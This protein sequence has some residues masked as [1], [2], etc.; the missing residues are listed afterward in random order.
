M[1][2][3]RSIRDSTFNTESSFTN[4]PARALAKSNGAVMLCMEPVW[5]QQQR[6]SNSYY[7]PRLCPARLSILLYSIHIHLCIHISIYSISKAHNDDDDDD[8][9]GTYISKHIR[10][11]ICVCVVHVL[12]HLV[13]EY[14]VR[15]DCA[16]PERIICVSTT[17]R[18]TNTTHYAFVTALYIQ[19]R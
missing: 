12:Y 17:T 4:A 11:R 16:K 7:S 2:I 9:I 1:H 6:Q 18:Y 5:S 10:T 14:F 15:S 13:K 19:T 3:R 8:S